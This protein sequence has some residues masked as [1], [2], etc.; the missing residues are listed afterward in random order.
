M[1]GNSEMKQY[2]LYSSVVVR[3]VDWLWYPYLP[4]GKLSIIQGDPGCGKSTLMMHLIACITSGKSLPNG[5]IIQ[6]HN[7]IYQ[8]SEDSICCSVYSDEEIEELERDSK[9]LSGEEH[10]RIIQTEFVGYQV[11]YGVY[12]LTRNMPSMTISNKTLKFNKACHTRFDDCEFIEVL[13]HPIL[14][15]VAIRACDEETPTSIR[16][17]SDAGKVID[18]IHSKAFSD[19]IFEKMNWIKDYSFQFRGFFR[20][21][22]DAKI[23]F[24]SLDEPRIHVGKKKPIEDADSDEPF[25]FIEYKN[26]TDSLNETVGCNSY[27]GEDRMHRCGGVVLRH[28]GAAHVCALGGC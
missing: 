9:V 5:T 10:S 1:S 2:E 27:G 16:W 20:E 25:K 14:Q 19:A 26:A 21:S 6:P 12:F 28:C 13:Y 18:S 24:F 3:N 23:L 15:M 4:Y 11:P 8:C 22:G 7:V 17:K